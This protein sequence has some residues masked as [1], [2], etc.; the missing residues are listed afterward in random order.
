MAELKIKEHVPLGIAWSWVKFSFA[1]FREKP[2]NFL[3]F[4]LGFV[5]FSLLPFLGSFIAVLVIARV[6]LTAKYIED[7]QPVGVSLNLGLIFRQRNIVSYGLFNLLFDFVMMSGLRQIMSGMGIDSSSPEAM[8]QDHRI[9]Y[10]LIG[11]S[12]FRAAFLGISLAIV[13]FNAEMKVIPALK[14]NWLLI[15][16]HWS[17]L[18]LGLFLLLPFLIIPLYLITLLAL[19]VSSS[20]AF[21]FAAF[22]LL[23]A[24][25]LFIAVT[26]IFSYKV[27]QDVI[28]HE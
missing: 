27:Y 9:I 21:G 18:A 5:I 28:S 11:F 12:V 1:T 13:T 10:L 20:I 26:T 17:T 19:S 8:M 7:D 14:L 4:A 23:I 3:F 16:K 6:Y 24:M 2:I 15:I 25:L 22:L